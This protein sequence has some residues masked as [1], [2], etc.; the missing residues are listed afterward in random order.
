M[1]FILKIK[2]KFFCP[3]T[4]PARLW[5]STGH[6]VGRPDGRPTCTDLCTLARHLGRSTGRSTGQESFALW[7]WAVDRAVDWLLPTV[8]NMT[9]GGRPAGRPPVALADN[10]SQRLVFGLGVYKPHSFGILDKFLK[11]KILP[12]L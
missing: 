1:G 3:K 8:K 7:F 5:R 6:R 9:V 2:T 10:F 11:K 4:V 12:F